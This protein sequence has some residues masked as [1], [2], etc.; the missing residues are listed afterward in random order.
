MKAK[1]I[2]IGLLLFLCAVLLG[3]F[4][5]RLV[6]GIS[7]LSWLA[8]TISVGIPVSQP[9]V[10]DLSVISIALGAYLTINIAQIIF[11][12]IALFLYKPLLKRL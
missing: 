1:R 7:A 9:F 3:E 8:Y 10:L 4:T 12:V 11:L 2:F 5:G 6:E